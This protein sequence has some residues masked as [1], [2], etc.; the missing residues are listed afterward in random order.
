MKGGQEMTDHRFIKE[1]QHQE[2]G[3]DKNRERIL[4]TP[5]AKKHRMSRRK[6]EH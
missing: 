5:P 6:V 1:Q 3:K 2:E 4:L